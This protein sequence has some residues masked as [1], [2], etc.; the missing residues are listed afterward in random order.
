MHEP[1][2]ANNANKQEINTLINVTVQHTVQKIFFGD[3]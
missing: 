2:E 1:S 3:N